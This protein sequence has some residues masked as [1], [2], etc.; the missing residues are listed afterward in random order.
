MERLRDFV[1]IVNAFFLIYILAYT[2][3]LFASALYGAVTV[4]RRARRAAFRARLRVN[5]MD[6]YFPISV[7]IPA[8]NEE[9]TILDT[10][11]S[12]RA[13]DY[14]EYEIVVVDDGSTDA[15][16]EILINHFH[17]KPV[18]RPIRRQAPCKREVAIYE[19][20]DEGARITLIIKENGGKADALNMGISAARYPYFLSLDADSVLQKD[21]LHNI[22]APILEDD[23]VIACGGMI[24]IANE[25]VIEEGV[26]KEYK[27]PR[28][29]LVLFQML[30]YCRTFLGSRILMDSFNG[31]MIISGACGLFKKD[32]VVQVGGYD[33]NIIGEDM[34]LVVKLHAFCRTRNVPY[35]ILYA[36]EAICWSQAPESL[37]DLRRQRKRWHTGLLQ[38]LVKHRHVLFNMKFGA[39]GMLSMVYYLLMEAIAPIIEWVG[40]IFIVLAALLEMLNIPFMLWYFF[41]FFVFSALVTVTSFFSR[42]YTL[43]M[44]LTAWQVIKVCL[45]SVLE[46]VGFRQLITMYRVSAL[47]GFRKNKNEWGKIQ[48]RKHN[49]RE[50]V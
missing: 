42:M 50:V 18:D 2:L 43:P 4:E 22:I 37:R 8:Y 26:V 27:F 39:V 32:V 28:R 7:L 14:P 36:P 16:S 46:C 41:L 29:P 49:R 9:I 1:D 21:T 40:L 24:Q 30:E 25:A 3:F 10:V 35:R 12:L 17:L 31:N 23:R 19:S 15:T 33:T 48:R 47:V 11:Q 34:E 44:R 20:T 38:S 13:V 5:N 45:F 6:N